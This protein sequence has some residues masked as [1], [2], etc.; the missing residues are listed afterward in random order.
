MCLGWVS[1]GSVFMHDLY[2][3]NVAVFLSDLQD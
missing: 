1:L 3:H 2:A